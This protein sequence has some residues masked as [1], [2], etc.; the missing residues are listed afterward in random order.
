MSR[1]KGKR[2]RPRG[3]QTG[4]MEQ[5]QKLQEE[6][7]KA[8]EALAEE[9]VTVT[10]GGGVITVVMT[11]HQR[12]QSVTIDPDVVDPDEEFNAAS[13][14]ALALP[15]VEKVVS[16]QKACFVTG[17]TGLYINSLTRGL[18]PCPPADPA[19]RKELNDRCDTFG[20]M[21]LYEKLR[22][23]DPRSAER[24]H[25]NDRIRIIRFLEIAHLTRRR[26]SDLFRDHGFSDH[27]LQVLKICLEIEREELY[28]RI[29]QRSITMVSS[30]LIEETEA[31]MAK[32]YGPDLKPMKSIGY[33]HV[34]NYLRGKW[35]LDEAVHQLQKDTRRYAKRQLTWFR[36]DPEYSWI[37][38]EDTDSLLSRVQSFLHEKS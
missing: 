10:A 36:A 11:G 3:G 5:I 12:L 21:P 8:Q 4:V 2:I 26:P 13:Y 22:R 14:R 17:G 15:A 1:G 16:G 34:V 37:R 38:P 23:V 33:R 29:N 18:F 24:I 7:V 6:L 31:L 27:P 32:G 30:G 20:T 28:N 25:P 35:S 19:F 9:T